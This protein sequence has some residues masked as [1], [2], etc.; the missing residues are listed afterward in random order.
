MMKETGKGR[1]SRIEL[2]YYR[3]PD[4]LLR[5]RR[6]LWVTA[7]VA[8]AGGLVAAGIA[9]RPANSHSWS[10]VPRRI[11]SKGPVAEPH[12]MWDAN[13][14]AC[15]TDFV[16]IN[17]TQWAPSFW[18]GSTA[19]SAK[20]KNCHAGPAHHKSELRPDVPACAQC[21]RDHRG[22]DASLLD[23][24]NSSC[25]ACHQNLLNHRDKA[26][27]SKIVARNERKGEGVSQFDKAN[28]PDLTD[29]W[30]LRSADPGRIKFN[31]ALHLIAGL[32]LENGGKAFTFDQLADS[33]QTRYGFGKKL[34]LST[35]VKLECASCHQPEP[36]EHPRSADHRVADTGPPRPEGLYMSPIVYE[37]HCAACHPLQFEEKRPDQFARHGIFAQETLNDLRQLYLSEAAKGD[38]ELLRQFVPPRPMPGQPSPRTKPVMSQAVDEKLTVAAKLL[39]GAAVDDLKLRKDNLPQ[40]RRGCV[41]CHNLKPGAGPIV[42]SS[43]LATL[44]I[45][46]PLMTPVWQTHALFN[47]RYHRALNC[48]ECHDNVST[49]K[50]NGG[51]HPLLPGIDTCVMCHAPARGWFGAGPGGA[52]TACVECHRYH[53]GD[54]P[55]QNLGATARQ[56]EIK[57]TIERFLSGGGTPKQN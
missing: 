42:N 23:V 46:R 7:I 38:P 34:P 53:N 57:Q 24:D 20:C 25:T 3:T 9:D 31:H 40:G 47:H 33:D 4:R 44:E 49:S 54:L 35:P 12:A 2:G 43:S 5:L 51:D 48:V 16:T 56:P 41:E 22:R 10:I 28:H 8:T 18:N 39:F 37:N 45:E 32:N 19:G 36:A 29:S 15:H 55:D 50:R 13:C 21:H 52:R 11:A 30:K 27:G 1:K 26:V 14:E 17:S 6:W